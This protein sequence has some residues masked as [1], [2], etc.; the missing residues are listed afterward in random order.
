[1]PI[2]TAH[3]ILDY[4]SEI[5]RIFG[6]RLSKY[7]ALMNDVKTFE[8]QNVRKIVIFIYFFS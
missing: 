7:K 1:M 5:R 2:Q 4:D 3:S 8:K 6:Q